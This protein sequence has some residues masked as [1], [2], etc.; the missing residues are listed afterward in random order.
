MTKT[1]CYNTISKH[2]NI[3][4]FNS[5]L[6]SQFRHRHEIFALLVGEKYKNSKTLKILQALATQENRTCN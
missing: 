6:R 5:N 1:K 3:I 4:I 2:E